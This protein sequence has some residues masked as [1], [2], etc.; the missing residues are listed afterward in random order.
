[1][2]FKSYSNNDVNNLAVSK[3]NSAVTKRNYNIS[4][5]NLT[6]Y[7][8]SN[9]SNSSFV[10]SGYDDSNSTYPERSP[11]KKGHRKIIKTRYFYNTNRRKINKGT[12]YLNPDTDFAATNN[13]SKNKPDFDRPYNFSENKYSDL[14]V[15]FHTNSD[16]DVTKVLYSDIVK[17][18]PTNKTRRFYNNAAP[19]NKN[20]A[21]TTAVTNTEL[22]ALSSLNRT[23]QYDENKYIPNMTAD[24]SF[25]RTQKYDDSKNNPIMTDVTFQNRTE[26][27][28]A[29]KNNPIKTAAS[30]F[31][32]TQKY[33]DTKCPNS[34]DV[35]LFN[36]TYLCD[37]VK[38]I[39]DE[40]DASSSLSHTHMV[41]EIYSNTNSD[42]NK[43]TI[44]PLS[45]LS[46]HES[47]KCSTHENI[48][49]P[50][51]PCRCNNRMTK[52]SV[53]TSTEDLVVP[54]VVTENFIDE[55]NI[56]V[57]EPRHIFDKK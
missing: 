47:N 33:D 16:S 10:S 50:I 17:N 14:A 22:T 57:V 48:P 53:A 23:K 43:L 32:R 26:M 55:S 6:N 3:T 27:C 42:V 1:L 31:V 12:T 56:P 39:S 41:D 21:H 7:V 28:D 46:V 19:T 2:P 35:T 9:K 24:T 13:N 34:T 20:I 36:R 15:T 4:K 11:T 52:I 8:N 37:D 30:S 5:N 40:T 44:L 29:N 51:I 18:N 54:H 49:E 45:E 25:F 38:T